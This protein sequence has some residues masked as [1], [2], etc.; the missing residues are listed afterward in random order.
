MGGRSEMN[1]LAVDD[2][3]V[4]RRH[5][6]DHQRK[7]ETGKVF[8]ISTTRG[9]SLLPNRNSLRFPGCCRRRPYY[10]GKLIFYESPEGKRMA[11]GSGVQSGRMREK[12]LGEPPPPEGQFKFNNDPRYLG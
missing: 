10:L 7:D 9:I 11:G 6:T 3:K 8:E 12:N 4:V 5:G 1:G 2:P